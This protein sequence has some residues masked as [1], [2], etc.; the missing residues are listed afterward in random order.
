MRQRTVTSFFE[1]EYLEYARYVVSNRAIPHLIDGLKPSQRK[2][3]HIANKI[4]KPGNTKQ[5]K[6][7]QLA[8]RVAAD[9]YYHHGNSSLESSMVNMVQTFKNSLP[10][11][12]GHG[13]FG[14]LREPEA[15]APRYIGASLHPNFHLIYKDFDLLTPKT[16]EG[17]EIEPEFF[18][19]IIPT[20]ILNGTSGIAVGFATKILNRKPLDVIE[21][22]TAVLKGSKIKP[23][24]PYV[25]GFSGTFNRDAG[26]L[27]SWSAHGTFRVV[28]TT[29]VHISEIPPNITCE[30]YE[31]HLIELLD[32]R[33]ISDYEDN[34]SGNID[35]TIKF[36]RATLKDL[37]SKGNLE[38]ILK[39]TSKDT[40]NLTVIDE[41]GKLRV[42]NSAEEIVKH[43]VAVRLTYYDK[44]KA[45]LIESLEREIVKLSN[46]AKFIKDIIDGKLK[47]NNIPKDTIILYLESNKFD[48]INESFTYL[49]NMPIYS[50][51]K[52]RF[53]E[54]LQKRDEAQEQLINVRSWKAH[55]MYLSDLTKLKKELSI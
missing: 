21:A 7:F 38:K 23:L 19:P 33:I 24:I 12:K 17:Y 43:F 32:K 9:S 31:K 53:E 48:M 28:N 3:I 40:E 25:E 26:N 13:Q 50:L 15:G 39:L 27:N 16:E 2:I 1:S 8:G 34:C 49:L 11:L 41:D 20:V 51:T 30:N 4:W 54:L 37:V 45:H 10:L 14:D 46:M 6:L 35:Y 22:C 29:T 42:F 36:T 18:L 55:D 44:R 52:E 47:V 5:M